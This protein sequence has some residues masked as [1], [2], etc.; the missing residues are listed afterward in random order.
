MS[1]A[2]FDDEA[3]EFICEYGMRPCAN[4]STLGGT[5]MCTSNVENDCPIT[6]LQIVMK[7]GAN[8]ILNDP[9]YVKRLSTNSTAVDAEVIMY[10]AF[11]TKTNARSNTPLQ[12]IQLTYRTPC[13][14]PT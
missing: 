10:A 7:E 14:F 4:N 6:D 3:N 1:R 8:P 12:S 13:A 9:N 2:T 11:T 5:P